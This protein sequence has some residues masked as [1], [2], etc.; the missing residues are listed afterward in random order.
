[1]TPALA[2]AAVASVAWWRFTDLQGAGDLRP[3]LLLQGLPLVLVPLLQWQHEAP[4]RER[5]AVGG[6]MVLYVLAK[7]FEWG[8]HGVFAALGVVSGHT[9]KHLLATLAA[10][11]I[12]A[13]LSWRIG[14]A[15]RA[16]RT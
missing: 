8:D 3:Y 5:L 13:M 15:V 1:M 16:R 9:I 6:A 7:V 11:L 12:G 10:A 14:G 2:A 4:M